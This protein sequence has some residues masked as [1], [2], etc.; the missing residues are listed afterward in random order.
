MNKILLTICARGGSKGVKNKN[1]RLLRGLPLIVY[2]IKQALSWGKAAHVV[3]STDSPEIAQIAKKFGAAVPFMRPPEL[4]TDIAPKIPVL[5]HALKS[6][7]K[8]F[9]DKYDAVL[10]LDPTA[11][12]RTRSD[13]DKSLKLFFAKSPKSLF[14]VVEAHKNP[15]FNM[16]EEVGG[17]VRLCKKLCAAPTSRQGAP[18]VYA[19]NA[20]IY[21]YNRDY[22]LNEKN[23][24]PVGDNSVIYLMNDLCGVD[25]D[26][27]I[28]FKFIEFLVKEK[29]I[30]L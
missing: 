19:M 29:T 16:V 21:V 13:L 7:E 28:D 4:A 11:P 22:L 18:K 15:Y 23:I 2:T 8:I 24:H 17:R 1:I 9:H 5:R 30:S 3:V 26:R 12:V 25:I 10:D 20:S 6:C 27:E 14:S